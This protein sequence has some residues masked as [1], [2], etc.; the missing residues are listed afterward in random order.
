MA[1]SEDRC[2]TS[3]TTALRVAGAHGSSDPRGR[4]GA[5]VATASQ[6]LPGLE[7]RGRDVLHPAAGLRLFLN[8]FRSAGLYPSP[9]G[10][11]PFPDGLAAVCP[12]GSR[13]GLGPGRPPLV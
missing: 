11:F 6:P 9:P 10:L 3:P 13:G 1:L 8:I 12:V 5:V 7:R 4:G 2:A